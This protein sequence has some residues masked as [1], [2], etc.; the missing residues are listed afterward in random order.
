MTTKIMQ[1]D[2]IVMM[3]VKS[4]MNVKGSEPHGRLKVLAAVKD[5]FSLIGQ[6]DCRP[7]IGQQIKFKFIWR[8]A[9]AESTSFP[10]PLPVLFVQRIQQ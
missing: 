4:M 5:S 9:A 10:Y 2:I 7:Q 1:F 6:R 3:N 8:L